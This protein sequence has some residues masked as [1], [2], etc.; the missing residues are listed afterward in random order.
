MGI[1]FKIALR[2]VVANRRR[3][4]LIGFVIFLASFLLIMAN[5]LSNGVDTQVGKSYFNIQAADAIAIWENAK[6][7]DTH[8]AS[9]L[10]FMQPN[11]FD[12]GKDAQ[13]QKAI[14]AM[15]SFIEAHKGEIDSY[16][17]L[18]RRN[19][20]LVANDQTDAQ[21]SVY[22][23][24][25]ENK[26]YLLK[27]NTVSMVE[28]DLMPTAKNGLVI[29]K[30]KAEEFELHVGD[31]VRIDALTPSGDKNSLEFVVEG[32]YA[33]G[34]GWDNWYGF[35]QESTSRELFQYKAGYFDIGKFYLKDKGQA[36]D[37]TKQLNDALAGTGTV[38]N[39]ET[40]QEASALF[41]T[42]GMTL[43]ALFITFILFLLIVIAIGLRSSIR[44]N[45]F[46][47][48]REFGTLRA[49]GYSRRQS[50]AIIFNE[51]FLLAVISMAVAFVPSVIL[52]AIFGKVGV[53]VG[54]GPLSYFGGE[55]LYPSIRF[56]DVFL[57]LFAMLFFALVSTFK[58]GMQLLYQTITD[59]MARRQ[60]KVKVM[61]SV[62]R[63]AF[64]KRS[65]KKK[66]GSKPVSM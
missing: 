47:R 3:S 13:N 18:V 55:Y 38:L 17:P 28:G 21:F 51:A 34:A 5:A 25:P 65:G 53:Y 27:T 30:E 44:M 49:I 62:W 1:I 42:M 23:L 26:D 45:L 20:E 66:D 22:G 24:T 32:I 35:M 36:A 46:E 37:F 43:K 31:K 15:N 56:S 12:M 52:V 14:A 57:A 16:Y 8:D 58:P 9:R 59:T 63:S 19:A 33:N 11:S 7:I 29:S 6:R 50:F 39:A 40:G 10:M 61:R 2:N 48:M 54:P 41:A 60:V 64:G 4:F